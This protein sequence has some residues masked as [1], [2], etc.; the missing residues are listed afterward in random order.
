MQANPQPVESAW[1]ELREAQ[2]KTLKVP[3][4]GMAVATDIGDGNDIHPKNKQEVGYRLARIALAKVYGVNIPYSGPLYTS[5]VKKGKSMEISF[6]YNDGL[7]A[8]GGNVLKGFAVAGADKVFHWADAKIVGNTILVT[9]K[10]VK[11]PVAVRYNW[12]DNPD[13]NLV[14]QSGL[15][16][17]SFRTDDWE[18]ITFGKTK[19]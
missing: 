3:N 5:F 19:I 18:G 8:S 4:T 16:A 2:L 1:A 7:K 13:G 17:S 6:N 11:D 14:N 15:P 12:A 9:S 10:D